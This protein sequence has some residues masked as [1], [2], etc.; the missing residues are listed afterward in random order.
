MMPAMLSPLIDRRYHA[1][2]AAM[3]DTPAMLDAYA[4]FAATLVGRQY[5]T[6]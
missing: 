1:A 3:V 2:A 4:C 5:A 6:R